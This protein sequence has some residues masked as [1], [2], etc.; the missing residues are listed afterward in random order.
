MI[1]EAKKQG[2]VLM[3]DHTFPYTGAVQ[4][5]KELAED[6]TL[7]T[8]QYYDSVRINL[9]L[10]QDD[11][12]VLWDLAVHDLSIMETVFP[13]KPVSVS[14]TGISHVDGKP[15]NTAYL[16]IF[17]EEKFIA[18]VAAS[19][20]APAKLRQTLIGGTE[21]MVVY[22]DM[23]PEEKVRLY[24][25][26]ITV[27]PSPEN[28]YRMR[29]GYRAGDVWIPKLRRAEALRELVSHFAD[30]IENGATPITSAESGARIVRILEAA[31]ES[32]KQQGAP[33]T[34]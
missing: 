23:E 17:Y 33:V 5:V 26:G 2:K 1:E 34:L 10:F 6:G 25:K 16:T 27:D 24:D 20:L 11:V 18:H 13:F 22:D 32:M 3:V 19:W 14:A 29:V 8:L 28:I 4:K 21:K 7:G 12:N 31:T 15:A 9:G 30:V